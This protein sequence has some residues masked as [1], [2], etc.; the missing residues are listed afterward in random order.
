VGVE[1]D[2]VFSW[3]STDAVPLNVSDVGGFEYPNSVKFISI[4]T[5]G[6]A[7]VSLWPPGLLRPCPTWG[8]T[9][10]LFPKMGR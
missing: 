6:A 9:A 3:N 10:S 7:L 4:F 1:S 5:E 2:A 8:S